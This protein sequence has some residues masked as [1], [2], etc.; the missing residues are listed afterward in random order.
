MAAARRCTCAAA[1]SSKGGG[2]AY[3]YWAHFLSPRPATQLRVLIG[4]EDPATFRAMP[5][6]VRPSASYWLP[7]RYFVM[8]S[9]KDITD[10]N[11]KLVDRYARLKQAM[12]DAQA[13]G[14]AA[15]AALEARG[16][17][18]DEGMAL[19]LQILLMSECS[20]LFGSY[21]SNVAI[22]VHDLMHARMVAK[23]DRMH[24]VDINGRTYC[25]CGA[26]FCMKLERRATREP[27]RKML[28]MVEAFRGNNRNAI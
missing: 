2:F 17:R 4:S 22:L 27:Q 15:V 18:K 12:A 26:S 11:N 9:F 3:K 10:N 21:A 14:G 13:S 25:G 19:V 28:N 8:D 7:G 5:P 6:L 16:V 24:A 23:R 1:T 20:A